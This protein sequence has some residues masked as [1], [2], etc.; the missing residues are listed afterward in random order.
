[1]KNSIENLMKVEN[2]LF[3][4]FRVR[5]FSFKFQW[6]LNHRAISLWNRKFRVFY[7]AGMRDDFLA[8]RAGVQIGSVT[9]GCLFFG[10]VCIREEKRRSIIFPLRNFNSINEW[11]VVCVVE[12]ARSVKAQF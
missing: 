8:S 9:Q 6:G 5:F 1:M 7:P 11:R 3:S 12:F 10:K 2:L 4:G